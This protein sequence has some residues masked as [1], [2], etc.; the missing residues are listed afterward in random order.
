MTQGW[1]KAR[2]S[3]FLCCPH[4]PSLKQ[5]AR[6]CAF[7]VLLLQF[8]SV[9]VSISA[10][11]PA[12][13]SI[14]FKGQAKRKSRNLCP[15]LSRTSTS[16]CPGA[17][18]CP[19]VTL[20]APRF[21]PASLPAATALGSYTPFPT[22][23][24]C[25]TG[26]THSSNS[27]IRHLPST[28]SWICITVL[29]Y[30]ARSVLPHH[31]NGRSLGSSISRSVWVRL[32]RDHSNKATSTRRQALLSVAIYGIVPKS[33]HAEARASRPKSPER[34]RTKSP[35]ENKRATPLI[36][37]VDTSTVDFPSAVSAI[38]TPAVNP[39]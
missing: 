19:Q 4:L 15:L 18:N 34:K 26:S 28:S 16:A 36:V 37:L 32:L 20:H 8:Y 7:L 17:F 24:V 33:L 39:A 9:R 14:A 6:Q 5:K 2:A 27:T 30:S 10:S 23:Q 21:S 31:P 38:S 29:R 13:E 3:S 35:S 25:F 22:A 1:P 12:S 11:E